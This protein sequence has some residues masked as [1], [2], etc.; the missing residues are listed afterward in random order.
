M[1]IK[2]NLSVKSY[3]YKGSFTQLP[4]KQTGTMAEHERYTKNKKNI[5]LK[6]WHSPG[7]WA[8]YFCYPRNTKL[9]IK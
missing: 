4:R 8:E 9:I 2:Q 6:N 1:K 7:A 5:L 3:E